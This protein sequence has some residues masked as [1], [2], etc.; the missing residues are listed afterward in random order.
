MYIN[1]FEGLRASREDSWCSRGPLFS[2]QKRS[3]GRT[4]ED[5]YNML[6]EC[7]RFPRVRVPLL[8]PGAFGSVSQKQFC[9]LT[10]WG[11]ER[12]FFLGRVGE[13][14][15]EWG[16][17]NSLDG[18]HFKLR[19]YFSSQLYHFPQAAVIMDTPH[20]RSDHHLTIALPFFSA[21]P[22]LAHMTRPSSVALPLWSLLRCA[23]RISHFLLGASKAL[24]AFPVM[25][26]TL[27]HWI[28]WTFFS[29]A[30]VGAL[31]ALDSCLDPRS[32]A[33]NI[34]AF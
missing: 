15:S 33:W 4:D 20:S 30:H 27:S 25:V 8:V 14:P 2:L 31:W 9:A 18:V 7:F 32:K 21:Q 13:P 17:L 5:V 1:K 22:C 26:P 16:R 29:S 19:L 34:I 23:G 12:A 28:Q 24:S 6:Q 11:G 10:Y 3:C